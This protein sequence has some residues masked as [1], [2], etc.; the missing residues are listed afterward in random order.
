MAAQV[1]EVF[2]TLAKRFKVPESML[3]V[4]QLEGIQNC[5]DLFYRL[6]TENDVSLFVTEV[7]RLNE[8]VKDDHGRPGKITKDPADCPQA[9]EFSRSGEAASFRRLWWAS[10]GQAQKDMEALTA[11]VGD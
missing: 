7:L 2:Q 11:E 3:I 10:K 8:G 1:P 4:L 5:D 6:P 9:A